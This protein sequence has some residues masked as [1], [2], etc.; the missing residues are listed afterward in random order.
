[1]NHIRSQQ[2]SPPPSSQSSPHF[3]HHSLQ[4]Q[5]QQHVLAGK[6]QPV[7]LPSQHLA[8]AA[9]AAP[10]SAYVYHASE[11]SRCFYFP[12]PQDTPQRQQHQP[13]YSSLKA[14]Q[15]Y[16][17]PPMHGNNGAYDMMMYTPSYHQH[18][19]QN[20]MQAVRCM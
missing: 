5:Q 18:Q 12:L 4:R 17:Q 2:R 10:A 11:H 1:M 16:H 3:K 19:Y 13:V 7:V 6:M 15:V 14:H 20:Q 8:Q 9:V